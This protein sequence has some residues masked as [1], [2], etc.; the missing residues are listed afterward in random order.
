MRRTLNATGRYI[1]TNPHASTENVGFHWNALCAMSWGR[2]AELYLRAKAIARKGDMEP[3]RQFY[4]KRLGLPWRE[5]LEDFK[6]EITPGGY[7]MG[8]TWDDEAAVDKRGQL[9]SPPFDPEQ[10]AAPLRILTVDCQ[11]DHF[12][13]LVRG[14][15][16]EGSSRLLWHERVPMNA[17]DP[18]SAQLEA[19]F[20]EDPTPAMV[21]GN[22][23][24]PFSLGT[25]NLCR[26]LK[27]TL[28]TDAQAD[29]ALSEEER[30]RQIA[31]FAWMQSA[32][33][34][35]VLHAVRAG[36]WQEAVAEFEFNLSVDTIPSLIAEISRIAT[37]AAAAA[38]EVVPKPGG[39]E[40][41]DAP[42]KS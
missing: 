28:F 34:K 37:L 23:L 30:Q 38:V 25:L 4:Q 8:Q 10:V 20:A 12:Y 19:A 26:Q 22:R 21:G 3:L 2:L 17:T 7:R 1:P 36:T 16:A 27:L 29:E 39:G 9:L 35:E 5:Y 40:D 11:M 18:R 42:P 41:R 32:P 6:L 14:W 33:L 24:R 31:A 13:L 15:S